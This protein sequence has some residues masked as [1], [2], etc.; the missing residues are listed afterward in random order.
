MEQQIGGIAT[1]FLLQE[2]RTRLLALCWKLTGNREVAEDL[3]QE[4]LLL[5]WR[6]IER[7]RDP[8]KRSQWMAGIARNISL[9]WLRQYGRDRAYQQELLPFAG[10][11]SS[12][13]QEE[14][15]ADEFDLEVELERKELID[16]LDRALALLPNETRTVLV[17]RYVE[18]SPL[19][20]IAAQLGTNASAVAMRLQRG[21]LALR[22]VLM[23]DLQ[24]EIV[25][26]EQ[27]AATIQIWEQTSLWCNLCGKHRLLG[28]KNPVLGTLYLK[29]P[30]CSPA[31]NEVVSKNE[32]LSVLKGMKSFKPAY[33]RLID[34]CHDY[35]RRALRDGAIICD[36]C[37][38]LNVA[39][40]SL[41]EDIRELNWMNR[42]ELKW[43]WR[44]DKYLINVVCPRCQSINCTTLDSLSLFLPEGRKFHQEHQRIRLLPY[45]H[46]EFAGRPAIVTSYESVTETASFDVISDAETY[47]VLKIY[48]GTR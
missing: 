8:E 32:I 31:S 28:Q 20:E 12:S 41:P 19:T 34:W 43:V 27:K 33:G 3:V 16:L 15:F 48:G 11:Q 17:R 5:A 18:E 2:E 14:L 26:Y 9:R 25:S 36:I 39:R 42:G 45:R 4:T 29:C 1:D 23:N 30:E 21:K 24:Q 47:E 22:K 7:L 10:E 44:Q 37:G 46:V 35:Y 13:T 40:L 38:E 6:D